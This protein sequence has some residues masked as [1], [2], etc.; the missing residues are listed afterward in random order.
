LLRQSAFLEGHGSAQFSR[1]WQ[2]DGTGFDASAAVLETDPGGFRHRDALDTRDCLQ[3][4]NVCI[5]YG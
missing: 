1:L 3:M 5:G 4:G 2:R